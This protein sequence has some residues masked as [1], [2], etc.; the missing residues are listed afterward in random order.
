MEADPLPVIAYML[1]FASSF[2]TF[3]LKWLC[4][5]NYQ[6]IPGVALIYLTSI[7]S[8]RIDKTTDFFLLLRSK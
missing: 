6:I 5:A 1:Y 7:K 8:L 3:L 4:M 2:K